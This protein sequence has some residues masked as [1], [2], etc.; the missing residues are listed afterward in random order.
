ML[1]ALIVAEQARLLLLPMLSEDACSSLFEVCERK[2]FITLLLQ[3]QHVY[4]L[5]S[6]STQWTGLQSPAL[7]FCTL[8]F[9]INPLEY[10]SSTF[11]EV[12]KALAD[13]RSHCEGEGGGGRSRQRREAP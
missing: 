4:S 5:Y 7:I 13:P 10:L 9:H 8:H 11:A 3:L 12:I 1:I 6:D 2:Q